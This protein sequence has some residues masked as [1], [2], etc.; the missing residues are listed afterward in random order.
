MELIEHST[1]I[2][3]INEKLSCYTLGKVGEGF[4]KK[5]Y[6]DAIKEKKKTKALVFSFPISWIFFLYLYQSFFKNVK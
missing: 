1:K 4:E 2:S 5:G 3:T 6:K